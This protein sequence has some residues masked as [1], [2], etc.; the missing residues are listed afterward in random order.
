MM[1]TEILK[2]ASLGMV[3]WH[4]ELKEIKKKVINCIDMA[5]YNM[6]YTKNSTTLVYLE[7]GDTSLYIK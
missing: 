5:I 1:M 7:V 3:C 2:F 4:K 6:V